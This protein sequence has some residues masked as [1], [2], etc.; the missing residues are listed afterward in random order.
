MMRF[1]S[2]HFGGYEPVNH[3]LLPENAMLELW[4]STDEN[5]AN[6]T[7]GQPLR[8]SVSALLIEKRKAEILKLWQCNIVYR[9]HF[10]PGNANARRLAHQIIPFSICNAE[11]AKVMHAGVDCLDPSCL[12]VGNSNE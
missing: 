5:F 9:F 3:P 11:L 1:F 12:A 8:S 10:P 4:S 6:L 2:K 7:L